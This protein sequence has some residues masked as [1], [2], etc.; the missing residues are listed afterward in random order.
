MTVYGKSPCIVQQD[1]EHDLGPEAVISFEV[2][3]EAVGKGRPRG[4][5]QGGMARFYTTEKT[6]TYE[7]LVKMAAQAAMHGRTP[8][9]DA[10]WMRTVVHTP[11]PPSAS[12]KKGAAMLRQ[13]EYPAKKPDASNIVK[14]IED[15]CNGIVYKDDKQIVFMVVRKI[16]AER[17]C[18]RV[19]IGS[20]RCPPPEWG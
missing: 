16:Y 19:D 15:A 11:I 9:E 1:S 18:V 7:N 4:V 17:A 3:G 6:R 8:I 14:S 5:F 10:V 13:E 20:M 2:S 12:G